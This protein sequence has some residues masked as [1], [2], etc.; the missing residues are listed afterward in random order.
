MT[1]YTVDGRTYRLA[2]GLTEFQLGMYVHLVEWKRAHLTGECG[3]YE[4]GGR[5][6]PYDILLPDALRDELQ[7]IYPPVARRVREH[8]QRFPFKLHKFVGHMASSR[9][10]CIN[11]FVPLL[12]HPGVAA[13]VLSGIN[14]EME[15]IAT[16]CLDQGFQIEYWPGSGTERGPMTPSMTVF[17][18]LLGTPDRFSSFASDRI[19]NAAAAFPALREW[20]LWYRGLYRV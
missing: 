4:H 8:Q 6:I 20:A 16:D 12:E 17:S 3:L 7:P 13:K 10:A 15:S 19:V 5:F 9:A 11:L 14:T 2:S 1:E 18:K